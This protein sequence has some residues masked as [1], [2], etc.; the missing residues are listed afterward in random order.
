[1]F[2]SLLS[3]IFLFVSYV[4]LVFASPRSHLKPRN[5]LLMTWQK[6]QETD[7]RRTRPF[8]VLNSWPTYRVI[9]LPG[10]TGG[11]PISKLSREGKPCLWYVQVGCI[12][13]V[14][15]VLLVKE[16]K[17]FSIIQNCVGCNYHHR[18]NFILLLPWCSDLLPGHRL[19]VYFP[20]LSTDPAG[21]YLEKEYSKFLHKLSLCLGITK[22]KCI[23]CVEIKLQAFYW[24][25]ERGQQS[26]SRYYRFY[27]GIKQ[28]V[29]T[30]WKVLWCLGPVWTQLWR[31]I[32]VPAGNRIIVI[33]PVDVKF[34]ESATS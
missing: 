16:Q 21:K 14:P 20:W 2:F 26:A 6:T 15:N 23:L 9:Y 24:V 34:T 10:W 8:D 22:W 3:F 31:N 33:Q 27:S 7:L 11:R 30:G 4:H 13:G 17:I 25:P 29:L 1:M 32:P 19:F 18:C 28:S 5:I 12:P